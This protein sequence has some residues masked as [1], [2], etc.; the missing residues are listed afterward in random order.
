MVGGIVVLA[1]PKAGRIRKTG[2]KKR[3]PQGPYH[4]ELKVSV[5]DLD[6]RRIK[7]PIDLERKNW[8]I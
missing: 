7:R 2:K 5:V 1:T 8:K 6:P 4:H 3:Y